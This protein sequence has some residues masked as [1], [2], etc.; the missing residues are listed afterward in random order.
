M[1]VSRPPSSRT[2]HLDPSQGAVRPIAI[3][4]SPAY[5]RRV[6]QPLSPYELIQVHPTAVPEVIDAA[7]R[8][9]ARLYHPDRNPGPEASTR[10][11]ELNAAY[12]MLRNPRQRAAYDQSS[13]GKS[14]RQN[15]ME[16]MHTVT[17]PRRPG[18]RPDGDTTLIDFGRYAGR[19]V[20]EIAR[21]DRDY[22]EWLRRHSSG[23]RYRRHIE[24]ALRELTAARA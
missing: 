20:R 11:A 9:L 19:S 7:F 10:M 8:A 4:L 6:N 5:R 24:E 21:H 1:G 22:L 15:M 18:Q 2:G 13:Q 16:R 23:V 12:A 3:R 17:T 14:P